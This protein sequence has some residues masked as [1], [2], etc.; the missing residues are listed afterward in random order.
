MLANLNMNSLLVFKEVFH[1][2]SM[3]KA[4][5]VLGLTQPGVSQHIAT[6]EQTLGLE[7]FIRE[8][9]ALIPSR[10]GREL[11]DLLQGHLGDI[12]RK[13]MEIM[14]NKSFIK[15][16]VNLGLPIEFGNNIVFPI[17]AKLGKKFPGIGFKIYYGLGPSMNENLLSGKFDFAFV[18]EIISSPY[19]QYKTVFREELVLCCRNSY[20]ENIETKGKI[21]NEIPFELFHYAAY[22]ADQSILQGWFKKQWV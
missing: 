20:L 13:L 1:T 16:Q 3:T 10:A 7:L 12:D 11:F 19:L 14:D 18:D 15:G 8:N 9:R 4:A 2:G 17:L 21:K 6:L 5:K 22:L